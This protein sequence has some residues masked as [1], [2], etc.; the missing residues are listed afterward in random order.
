M[1]SVE[2]FISPLIE[3]QFPSFYRE[4]GP[5]FIAFVKAYYEWLEENNNVLYYARKLPDF[6]DIDTTVDQF[7]VY[8]K[9][10][11]L[12][13]V[14]FNTA[15]N[16]KL[17]L[18]NSQDL[19]R[20]RGT[21]RAIE[22]F[23]KLVYGRPAKVYYPGKDLMRLS[24]GEWVLPKYL[25]VEFTEFNSSY[26][27]KQI[28][29]LASGAT[30]FVDSISKTK[31]LLD[32]IDSSGNND[33]VS[34]DI[35]VFFMSD[36]KGSFITG[37]RITHSDITDPRNTT[38]II[39]SLN[40]LN[41]IAGAS[42]Y[43]VKDEV[44]ISSNTGLKGKAIVTAVVQVDGQVDFILENG[45]WGYT[46][47]PE[48]IISEKVLT[49]NNIS[50]T[51]NSLSQPFYVFESLIQPKANIY[52]NILTGTFAKDDMIYT[53]S[54]SDISGT[55]RVLSIQANSTNGVIYASVLSGNLESNSI[56]YKS[57]NSA[58]ACTTLYTDRTSLANVVGLT[59]TQTLLINDLSGTGVFTLNERI[60]QSNSLG[61]YA[62]AYIEAIGRRGSNYTISAANVHGAFL[63]GQRIRGQASGANGYLSYY[64][65][66]VGIID[67]S[68]TTV[69]VVNVLEQGENYSNGDV[70]SFFSNTGTGA[71]AK[72]RTNPAGNV[73]SIN[74][75]KGGRNYQLTPLVEIANTATP[76]SFNAN[77]DIDEEN[78]FITL[79][80][81]NFLNGQAV[82][83]E[84]ASG[85]TP[86]TGLTSGTIY[87]VRSSNT[88]GV[89][90]S[91]YP[92]GD[93]IAL[94]KGLSQ[95]GHTLTAAVSEGFGA[96]LE[97]ELGHAFDFTTPN[98]FVYGSKSNSSGLITFSSQGI[99]GNF[100]VGSIDNE[101]PNIV[102]SDLINGEN[103]YGALYLDIKISDAGNT[104]LSGSNAYGFP[105]YPAG[106]LTF[107]E[108]GN[109]FGKEQLSL[110]RISSIIKTNP[111]Q[112]YNR[113]PVVQILEP[114]V[115]AHGHL[116]YYLTINQ[117]I[118]S[119]TPRENI[120]VIDRKQFEGQSEVVDS[121]ISIQNNA[122]ANSTQVRYLTGFG[123]GALGG[124]ANNTTYYVV[125][126]N[127]SGLKLSTVKEGPAI[128]ITP[129]LVPDNNHYLDSGNYILSANYREKI[130]NNVMRVTRFNLYND[131]K[132]Q[133]NLF[134]RGE[135]SGAEAF[136]LEIN[137]DTL[138]TGFNAHVT[139]NVVVANGSVK[140]LEVID[141]GFGFGNND[142]VFFSRVNDKASKVGTARVSAVTHGT[143]TGFY[144]TSG[145][146][147]SEDKY[148]H[149]GDYYQE[150]SYEVQTRIPL[151]SYSEMLKNILHVAGTKTFAS[152][153]IEE[154]TQVPIT[155]YTEITIE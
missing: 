135:S 17:L 82:R 62:S 91:I 74:L 12:K 23:F 141:S 60:Y 26:E 144:R 1:K 3:S 55:G 139:S 117:N 42:D 32:I 133:A 18:K 34:K 37:E 53:Y 119:F 79:S 70:V 5:V 15:T 8:F 92:K 115:Y 114:L 76:Y 67:N 104:A 14:K 143:G 125:E 106:N 16:K 124:L 46:N 38:K 47:T 137:D 151:S 102:Y 149:D 109:I 128:V 64:S 127:T 68:T 146:F 129:S 145:G 13:Y 153:E 2:S 152:V 28:K 72:V 51:T 97:A 48:V 20:S 150:Y 78:K 11:Y 98:T 142:I 155:A 21:E 83:Y 111:G 65:C 131:L 116:D 19:Y 77:N 140:T 59:D 35:D 57:G 99:L 31:K 86:L 134:I 94:T 69:R 130:T 52:F 36:L 24:D 113:A 138:Y 58:S 88:T 10:Q 50:I 84:V 49:V 25:E 103:I 121:F 85:N 66:D 75:L 105:A 54:D 122:F 41:V 132:P 123:S 71:Y 136:V 87:Y 118:S 4:E 100:S 95:S 107:G 147:A 44:E 43:N 112:D 7:L 110:G 126:S 90:L 9:E 39:G 148:L 63:P 89:T 120:L 96:I 108:L 45:G 30:A 29:G 6:D 73:T 22:L 93:K 33:R 61:E 81:H 56:F 27:G 80:S 40:Y 154:K 101:E